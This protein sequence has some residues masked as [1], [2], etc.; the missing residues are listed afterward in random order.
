[1]E[2]SVTIHLIDFVLNFVEIDLPYK[3]LFRSLKKNQTEVSPRSL[4]YPHPPASIPPSQDRDSDALQSLYYCGRGISRMLGRTWND[5][6]ELLTTLHEIHKS[7][8]H[9]PLVT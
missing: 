5:P 3:S 9:V 1:M 2:V 8:T 6:K 7:Y 4:I